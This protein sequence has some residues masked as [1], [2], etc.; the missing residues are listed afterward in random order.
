VAFRIYEAHIGAATEDPNAV[1]TFADFER[2]VLW[3]V[4][5]GGYNTLQLSASASLS[6]PSLPLA[7]RSPPRFS[8]G[9][10]EHPY[11][12]SYGYQVS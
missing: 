5:E 4:K 2:H 6:A 1:G 7:D 8:M 12:A 10:M 11:Y 9:I 3:R